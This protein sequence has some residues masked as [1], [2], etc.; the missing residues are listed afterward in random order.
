MAS[1]VHYPTRRQ[2]TPP[3]GGGRFLHLAPVHATT[4]PLGTSHTITAKDAHTS[5]NSRRMPA[6]SRNAHRA[7]SALNRTTCSA[8]GE[9][10]VAACVWSLRYLGEWCNGGRRYSSGN[11]PNACFCRPLTLC[12]Q[13]GTCITLR[14]RSARR[15]TLSTRG[16]LVRYRN[17]HAR[18]CSLILDWRNNSFHMI[19]P[20][21]PTGW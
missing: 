15:A 9:V 2:T 6:P 18:G 4:R 1:D 19:R 7:F 13:G 5:I 17:V 8:V 21:D 16:Q 10:K 14:R 12:L 20:R 11:N 3:R